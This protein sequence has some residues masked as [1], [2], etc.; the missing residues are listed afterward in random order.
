MSTPT[1]DVAMQIREELSAVKRRAIAIRND[2]E[3]LMQAAKDLLTALDREPW[4]GIEDM[5]ERP[6]RPLRE[7]VWAI[8]KR[9]S[10]E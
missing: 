10:G 3:A 2:R 1:L 4:K 9:L 5:E 7:A 6:D 8:E